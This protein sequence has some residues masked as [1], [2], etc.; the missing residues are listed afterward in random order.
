MAHHRK[1][2]I[3]FNTLENIADA[4]TRLAPA[5]RYAFEMYRL[6]GM[7]QKDIAK[8]LGVSP[9]LVNFMIRDALVHCRKVSDSHSDDCAA[10]LTVPPPPLAKSGHGHHINAIRLENLQ[11]LAVIA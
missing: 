4:L 6:H 10:G 1:P 7:P 9:T 8:E 3:N 11:H 2:P 5:H